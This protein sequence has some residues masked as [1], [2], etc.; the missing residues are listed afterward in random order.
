LGTCVFLFFWLRNQLT[1]V[2]LF[3][4]FNDLNTSI[5]DSYN[6]RPLQKKLKLLIYLELSKV[7]C[8]RSQMQFPIKAIHFLLLHMVA[9]MSLFSISERFHVFI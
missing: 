5:S 4:E 6:S 2:Y 3:F 1:V 8:K 7:R 9:L